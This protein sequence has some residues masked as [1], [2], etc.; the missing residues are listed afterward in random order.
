VIKEF[1]GSQ[2]RVLHRDAR[3]MGGNGRDLSENGVF[4]ESMKNENCRNVGGGG[5]TAGLESKL[6]ETSH[7]KEVL[8]S[9]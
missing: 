5:E 6:V 7:F 4:L 2:S 3:K 8:G 9:K 1:F